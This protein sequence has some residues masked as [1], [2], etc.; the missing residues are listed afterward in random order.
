MTLGEHHPTY[1]ISLNNLAWLLLLHGDYAGARP[2]LEHALAI[3]K[4]T[5]G[6]RHPDYANSL[7]NLGFLHWTQGD[8]PGAA[9]LYEQGLEIARNNLDLVPKQA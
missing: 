8:R 7:S 5:L 2:L 9:C 4:A 3:R 6:E 1:A